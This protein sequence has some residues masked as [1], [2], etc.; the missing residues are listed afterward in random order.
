MHWDNHE[1]IFGNDFFCFCFSSRP[2]YMRGT[3]F[4]LVRILT[5]LIFYMLNF[6]ENIEV[7]LYFL[8]FIETETEPFSLKLKAGLFCTLSQ[9]LCCLWPSD[10][11]RRGITTNDIDLFIPEYFGLSII[12]L[13]KQFVMKRCNHAS[14]SIV[15]S[16]KSVVAYPHPD[17]QT[18]W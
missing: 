12:Y 15:L 4:K 13:K 14:P 2:K 7:C 9:Y 16:F 6:Q 3:E 17:G 10:V 1:L 18:G 11:K 5:S 8:S